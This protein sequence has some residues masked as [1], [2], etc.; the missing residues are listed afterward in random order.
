MDG[1]TPGMIPGTDGMVPIIAT[2]M[3]AGT[4]GAGA[5]TTTA[6]GTTDGII[7]T[8][9]AATI[10]ADATGAT[11]Q[12]QAVIS[13]NALQVITV[14]AVAEWATAAW[15]P[16]AQQQLVARAAHQEAMAAGRQ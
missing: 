6:H 2:A 1:T 5:G 8:T 10:M 15:D 7:R 13:D 9:T 4:T 11:G 16:H 14:Q 12:R 3:Q